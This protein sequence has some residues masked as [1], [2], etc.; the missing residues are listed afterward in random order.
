[1]TLTEMPPGLT[2]TL[3]P[4]TCPHI[5]TLPLNFFIQGIF[6]AGVGKTLGK[7]LDQG[8]QG[9]PRPSGHCSNASGGRFHRSDR[10]PPQRL[11][12][13]YDVC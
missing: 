12:I 1:M 3:P 10:K 11:Q 6:N 13:E 5:A 7:W 4:L 8:D 2:D 9:D